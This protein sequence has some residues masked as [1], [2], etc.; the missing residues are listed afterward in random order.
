MG[1]RG[2][3]FGTSY[4]I[5]NPNTGGTKKFEFTHSTGAEFDPKTRWIYKS[6]DGIV[7]E[8]C[9]DEE[10]TKIAADVY[11]KAKLKK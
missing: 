8:V 11:L 1:E 5:K 9:N 6:E 2:I 10:M 4:V 3:P 7:L